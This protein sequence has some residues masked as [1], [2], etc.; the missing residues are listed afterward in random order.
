MCIRERYGVPLNELETNKI[1]YCTVKKEKTKEKEIIGDSGRNHYME[2]SLS[3]L[4]CLGKAEVNME[5]DEN[6]RLTS[7]DV[8]ENAYI[9]GLKNYIAK[10][11]KAEERYGS[12][13]IYIRTM[14]RGGQGQEWNGLL[15]K[16]CHCREWN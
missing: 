6:F 16:I 5:V 9:K 11:A 7:I 12:Y 8:E 10:R 4:T 14:H 2:Y 13:D 1:R 15:D 3:D